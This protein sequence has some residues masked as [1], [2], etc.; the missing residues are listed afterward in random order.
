MQLKL[1][2]VLTLAAACA[3]AKDFDFKSPEAIN[4]AKNNWGDIKSKVDPLI[5]KARDYLSENSLSKIMELFDEGATELPNT[6]PKDNEWY[7]RAADILP[8]PLVKQIGSDIIRKCN[9]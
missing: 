9:L 5:S 1:P 8:A 7:K 3:L 6:A 4:C 2:G